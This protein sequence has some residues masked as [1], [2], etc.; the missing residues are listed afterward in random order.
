M[1]NRRLPS[2]TSSAVSSGSH[3]RQLV[4]NVAD[5]LSR[6]PDMLSSKFMA[7]RCD[8]AAAMRGCTG[9]ADVFAAE[10]CVGNVN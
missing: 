10:S 3:S 4:M 5:T 2:T 8:S 1:R 7:P 6:Q 9:L